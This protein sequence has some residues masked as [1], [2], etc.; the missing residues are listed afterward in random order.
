MAKKN[1]GAKHKAAKKRRQEIRRQREA[2]KEGDLG[3]KS[4]SSLGAEIHT[5]NLLRLQQDQKLSVISV[6]LPWPKSWAFSN[7]C[8]NED[9]NRKME[10]RIKA[11]ERLCEKKGWKAHMSYC[12][13]DG[14]M[15]FYVQAPSEEWNEWVVRQK[16]DYRASVLTADHLRQSM[17]HPDSDT[18][19]DYLVSKGFAPLIED[20]H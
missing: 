9:T 1:K 14:S 19:G 7:A 10:R 18:L 8:L 20:T 13:P 2:K 4:G 6:N 3:P 12:W 11:F 17:H 15:Y 5:R 16:G